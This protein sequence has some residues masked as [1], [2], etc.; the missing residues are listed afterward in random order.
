MLQSA[1]RTLRVVQLLAQRGRATLTEVAGELSISPSMAHR[2][3]TTCCELGFARQDGSGGMYETGAAL[4]E[5]SLG[6]TRATALRDAGA[7]QV[8]K[9]CKELRETVSVV[10]LEGRD[11]RFVET[12]EGDRAVRVTSPIG[13]TMPAHATAG[14]RAMLSC[15]PP[16]ELDRRFPTHRLTH[17]PWSA[18]ETWEELVCELDRVRDRGWAIQIG[19]G[20]DDVVAVGY[21]ILDGLGLPRAA[22]VASAPRTRLATSHDAQAV[23]RVLEP[24]ARK[25]QRRLRGSH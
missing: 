5:L 14:G 10:V 19:E 3:L 25:I 20:E 24:H 4:H 6:L 1:E 7:A 8:A 18:I 11:V 15:L 22:L 13:R 23:A 16:E 2:L 9:A 17:V 12:L 21:P